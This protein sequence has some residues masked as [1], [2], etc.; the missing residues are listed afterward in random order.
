MKSLGQG[1]AP[2][3]TLALTCRVAPSQWEGHLRDGRMFYVRVRHGELQV[4]VSAGPTSDPLDAVG[5]APALRIFLEDPHECFMDEAV[6]RD[7]TAA[8]LDFSAVGPAHMDP[9]L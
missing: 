8:V 4:R 6:M 5:A 3:R 1:A 9:D 7:M 2:V